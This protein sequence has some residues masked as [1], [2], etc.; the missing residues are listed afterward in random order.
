MFIE[1]QK[2][3]KNRYIQTPIIHTFFFHL[4]SLYFL[5]IDF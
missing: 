1:P 3:K 2:K 4:V 5:Y